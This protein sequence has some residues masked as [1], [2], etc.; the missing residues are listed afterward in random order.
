MIPFQYHLS[1]CIRSQLILVS[2]IIYSL[3]IKSL[4]VNNKASA[5]SGKLKK[6]S[7]TIGS[8]LYPWTYLD[9]IISSSTLFILNRTNMFVICIVLIAVISVNYPIAVKNIIRKS[10]TMFMFYPVQLSHH[11]ISSS[12]SVMSDCRT[13][14]RHTCMLHYYPQQGQQS[15]ILTAVVVFVH[16]HSTRL[17]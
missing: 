1:L 17:S 5:V 3:D 7:W 4:E 6:L 2:I 11:I 16:S 10:A 14:T 9:S 13:F 12:F 8:S 15:C